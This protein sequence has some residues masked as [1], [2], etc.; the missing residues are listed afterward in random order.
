MP[1]TLE[2]HPTAEREQTPRR[3]KIV[4][5]WKQMYGLSEKQI[6]NAQAVID[7]LQ[8][9][10]AMK[11]IAWDEILGSNEWKLKR[12]YSLTTNKLSFVEIVIGEAIAE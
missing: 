1:K 7:E 11:L 6:A 12:A 8:G 2:E 3:R 5:R 9:N 4:K 10:P